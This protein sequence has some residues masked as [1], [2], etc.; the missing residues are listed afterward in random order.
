LIETQDSKL[1]IKYQQ[2]GLILAAIL[3]IILAI[4]SVLFIT[5]EYY[6]GVIGYIKGAPF[7]PSKS[8]RIKTMMELAGIRKDMRVVDLGSGDGSIVI[9]AAQ[10]G[11]MAT[12]IEMNP[13]LIPYSRWRAKR[14]AVLEKTQFIKADIMD[15]P[16]RDYDIVF[17]YLLPVLLGKIRIKLSKELRQG[18]CVVSNGFPIPEWIPAREEN[19]IFLYRVIK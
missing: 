3:A 9:A 5:L 10:R 7:V 16:L 8:D 11:A 18:A 17:V 12:G 4:F 19:G 14:A 2:M 13:F 15:I 6:V 1:L